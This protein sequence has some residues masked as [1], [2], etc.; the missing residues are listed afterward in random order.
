MTGRAHQVFLTYT[1]PVS[2]F[3]YAGHP[4]AGHLYEH[5]NDLRDAVERIKRIAS[6]HGQPVSWVIN[7]QEYLN[8]EGLLPDLLRWKAEGDS[9]LVTMDYPDAVTSGL[10]RTTDMV[11]GVLERTRGDLTVATRQD[12]L[13]RALARLERKVSPSSDAAWPAAGGLTGSLGDDEDENDA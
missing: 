10:R 8:R 4:R 2:R 6:S 13:Q 1:C 12:S 7:D 5:T 3:T 11:R 9:L